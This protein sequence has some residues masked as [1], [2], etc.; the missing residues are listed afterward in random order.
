MEFGG[1]DKYP[2]GASIYLD[3][4]PVS[5]RGDVSHLLV[6]PFLLLTFKMKLE[7]AHKSS[8]P[9]PH[10]RSS[11][12]MSEPE[13]HGCSPEGSLLGAAVGGQGL[14]RSP[15]QETGKAGLSITWG[16]GAAAL[17]IRPQQDGSEPAW[18]P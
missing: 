15:G 2:K 3:S 14:G 6:P 4:L 13:L 17:V 12:V 11:S 1:L 7:A 5:I 9:L 8:K 10:F 16:V 18:A